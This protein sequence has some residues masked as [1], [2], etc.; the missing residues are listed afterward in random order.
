MPLP[1][2]RPATSVRKIRFIGSKRARWTLAGSLLI[3]LS[4][5][6]VGAVAWQWLNHPKVDRTILQ[7]TIAD[8]TL[9]WRC[10]QGHVFHAPGQLGSRPCT[11]CGQS[12]V[13]TDRY[14]CPEHGAFDVLLEFSAYDDPQRP[15]AKRYRL[16]NGSWQK[17][18]DGVRCP[19][20]GAVMTRFSAD[21]LNYRKP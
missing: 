17:I 5:A 4:I 2:N 3:P 18:A 21:P 15:H 11:S 13:P 14:A 8:F 16:P 1:L 19:R 6:L 12:A 7:R 10:D 9:R 20:C